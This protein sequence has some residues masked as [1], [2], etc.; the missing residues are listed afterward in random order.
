MNDF[1]FDLYGTDSNAGLTAFPVLNI[2][3]GGRSEGMAGA[4]SAVCDDISFVEWNPAGSSML[5]RTE[6]AFYHNNW[7]A[8]TKIESAIFSSRLGN[9]G[10]AAA[11]KWLYTPFTEYGDWGERLSKGYYSEIAGVLNVSYNFF[12][13]YYFSGISVGLNVKAAYRAMPDF[14][15]YTGA[16]QSAAGFMGDAGLLTRINFLKFYDSRDK[17]TSFAF[18]LRNIGPAV[19]G[20]ALPSLAVAAISYRPFRPLLFSFDFSLPVNLTDI[21]LSEKPFFAFGFSAAI[22]RFLSMRTGLQ[23]KAGASRFTLGTSIS[24]G[25]AALEINYSLDLATQLQPL[26]RVTLGVRLDL[27][28]GGRAEVA[29]MVDSYYLNGLDAYSEGDDEKALENFSEA[30]KI[31]PNFDPAIEGIEAIENFRSLTDR[32]K[33]MEELDL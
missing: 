16:S 10:L 24:L 19:M 20:D 23:L 25:A 3:M 15:E 27:G 9:F 6:L 26:N 13:G 11:G 7:I 33:R 18:V 5:F 32:I 8:D 22:T 14:S 21:T 28:D 30:L 1:F 2:P 31:N 29:R 17:N 12:P 4:F